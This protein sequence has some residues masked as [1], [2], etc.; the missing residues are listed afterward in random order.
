MDPPDI[1]NGRRGGRLRALKPAGKG[2]R[3][4]GANL[5]SPPTEAAA[6]VPE[7][8]RFAPTIATFHPVVQHMARIIL[9]EELR[10]IFRRTIRSVT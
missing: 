3:W 4:Y 5:T 9:M 6:V 10:K 8:R 7:V 1:N 2:L